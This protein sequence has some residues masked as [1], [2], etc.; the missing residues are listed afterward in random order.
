MEEKS[1]LLGMMSEICAKA[2]ILLSRLRG[3]GLPI[4]PVDAEKKIS[5]LERQMSEC[6]SEFESLFAR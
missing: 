3:D 6:S 1:V 2:K 4:S 5:E